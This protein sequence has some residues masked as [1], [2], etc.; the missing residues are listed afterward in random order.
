MMKC[1]TC[2]SEQEFGAYCLNCGTP[3]DTPEARI[4][5]QKY[6]PTKK[7]RMKVRW[8]GWDIKNKV[9]EIFAD[10]YLTLRALNFIGSNLVLRMIKWILM[11]ITFPIWAW[12][13]LW[14]EIYGELRKIT[15]SYK[16]Y[17]KISKRW[18]LMRD[19]IYSLLLTILIASLLVLMVMS[20]LSLEIFGIPLFA[21]L[22]IIPAVYFVHIMIELIILGVYFT[23]I[24]MK[25][26]ISQVKVQ[27]ASKDAEKKGKLGKD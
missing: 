23:A 10:W 1:K 2:E 19:G 20:K 15:E 22:G 14:K 27:L 7:Q 25:N 11:G 8:G 21:F 9:K 16:P 4:L 13:Y 6:K 12:W 26:H 18:H 17:E 24:K 5:Q 3:F